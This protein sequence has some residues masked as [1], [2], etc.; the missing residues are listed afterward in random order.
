MMKI[1]QH[2]RN[3]KLT[4]TPPDNDFTR[5]APPGTLFLT[6]ED[7]QE[8]Y[9]CQQL[10]SPN[11][12]KIM[13][14]ADGV[15]WGVVNKPV[16]QRGDIYAVSMLWPV[17]MSVVEMDVDLCPDNCRGDGKWCYIDKCIKEIPIDYISIAESKKS[18]LLAESENTIQL[19]ERAVRLGM[20][21]DEERS[22]LKSWERYSV[23]LSRVDTANPE[24]PQ[25]PE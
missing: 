10:F 2:I 6:S 25:K 11:T 5:N 3:F 16:P 22:Q 18:Q 23:L 24:W 17:D 15:I 21:T 12:A 13:Y 7:G 20:A 4:P 19:L 1:Y 9:E 14:D 8:W